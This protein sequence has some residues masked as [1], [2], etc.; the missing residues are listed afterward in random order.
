MK[1]ALSLSALAVLLLAGP[2]FADGHG[3][4]AEA[5]I[6]SLIEKAYVHGAFNELDPEAM[7]KGFHPDFAIFSPDGEKIRKFPIAEWTKRTAE[8]KAD[9]EFEP[10]NNRWTHDFASVDVTGHAASVKIELS[11]DGT[12]VF[13]D[14]L[15]L[16]KFESGWRVV[17]KVY[18][19][20]Q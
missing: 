8:R 12:L 3:H 2:A 9:P 5:D 17:G 16:L 13:T 6:K 14:Y 18:F 10:E 1:Y 11:K 15:S 4:D 7:E 19:R 20:H